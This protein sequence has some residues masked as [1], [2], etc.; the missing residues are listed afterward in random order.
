M[1]KSLFT[2]TAV[3]CFLTAACVQRVLESAP[4]HSV[5]REVP[6][7]YRAIYRE[8]DAEIDRQLPL[9]PL[10]WGHKK[11]ETAFGVELLAADSN[12]GEALLTGQVLPATALTLDHLK[13]LGVQSVSLSLQVPV[14]TRSHPRA[15]EYREFYRKVAADIRRRGLMII[16]EL[17]SAFREP[18]L[19]R[20]G[21]DYRGLKR[22]KFGAA[23]REMAEAVIADIRPD[24][25]TI[26]SEPDTQTRNTGLPFSPAEFAATIGQVVKELDHSGVKFGAGA[27]S[28]VSIDYFRA[29]AA[30]PELDYID[31]HIYPVQHGFASDRVLKAAEAARANGKRVSIGQ[32][33]L[34]KVLGRELTRISPVEAFSRDVFSFWQPLDEN[35]IQL[36]VNL[37]RTIDAE[38]CSFF[39]MEHFFSYLDYSAETSQLPYDQLK[40]MIDRRAGENIEKGTLSA[41]GRKF[42]DLVKR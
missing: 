37:A 28:W 8:I 40:R 24:F 25:L 12:R 34:Y 2:V 29:L 21:A 11:T 4:T 10:P 38:F 23:L 6:E 7:N 20:I 41:T 15:G 35:F 18:E 22:D 9:I 26:L 39:R 5:P 42:R 3:C 31:I 1:Q 16:V 27:G 17:G 30:I 13:A 32:A 19:S 36:V 33:W 14:L